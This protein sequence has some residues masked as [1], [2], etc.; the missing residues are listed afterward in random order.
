MYLH[1]QLQITGG[2]L[3]QTDHQLIFSYHK[4]WKI[5]LLKRKKK[6]N[7]ALDKNDKNLL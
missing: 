3:I 4:T 7:M 2:Q 6:N 1:K 5:V